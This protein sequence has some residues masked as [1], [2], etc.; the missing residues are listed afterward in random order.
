MYQIIC[1][2]RTLM[3]LQQ[4]CSTN[5]V[6]YQQK[7][8]VDYQQI[9]SSTANLLQS[10][11]MEKYN[12]AVDL[13]YVSNMLINTAILLQRVLPSSRCCPAVEYLYSLLPCSTT[14]AKQQTCCS[15]FKISTAQQYCIPKYGSFGLQ[16]NCSMFQIFKLLLHSSTVYPNMGMQFEHYRILMY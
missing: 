5:A 3:E 8:P 14:T 15:V 7:I 2:E 13:Q 12:G 16:Q 11:S 9:C 6:H 4:N 1:I 10:F